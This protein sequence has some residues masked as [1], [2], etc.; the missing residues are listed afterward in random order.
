MCSHNV[1]HSMMIECLQTEEPR[2]S[3]SSNSSTY[4]NLKRILLLLNVGDISLLVYH[5]FVP[6]SKRALDE[7]C[8]RVER[9]REKIEIDVPFTQS[10]MYI[11]LHW[12][13]DSHSLSMHINNARIL[14]RSLLFD[15]QRTSH[16]H[17]ILCCILLKLIN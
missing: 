3:S 5:I 14:R 9:H 7:Q 17:S 6:T 2:S 12:P 13:C 11:I 15:V 1:S 16:T 8:E 4:R 10:H